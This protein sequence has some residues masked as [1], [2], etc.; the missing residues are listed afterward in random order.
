MQKLQWTSAIYGFFNEPT[1]RFNGEHPYHW[2]LCASKTCTR[3]YLD[4]SDATSTGNLTQ[5]AC[6]C[7]GKDVV[8]AAK[9]GAKV[10]HTDGSI[11]GAW[12]RQASK[13][14]PKKPLTV[15]SFCNRPMHAA[16]DRK[17]KELLLDRQPGLTMPSQTTIAQ[18]IKTSFE[19]SVETVTKL[20]NDHRGKISFTTDAWTSPNHCA[21]VAWTAHF[22]HEGNPVAFL[23]D[24]Y[25]VPTSH[26]SKELAQAF[27]DMLERYNIQ[28]KVY[29]YLDV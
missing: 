3:R 17:L 12:A 28:H 15:A 24:I 25:E 13:P 22:Q 18:D 2:F 6:S 5:H 10:K 23:I 4:T 27:Q 20:L 9:S 21:F 11:I 16:K 8:N 19:R 26:G 29:Q 7:F 1:L 14:G